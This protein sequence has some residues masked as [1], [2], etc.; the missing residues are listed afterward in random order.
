MATHD[1]VDPARLPYLVTREVL[2]TYHPDSDGQV[3]ALLVLLRRLAAE[4]ARENARAEVVR[5]TREVREREMVLLTAPQEGTGNRN[6]SGNSGR[7]C[8]PFCR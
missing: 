3:D 6:R 7:L 8:P 1:E 5:I 4:A 2:K